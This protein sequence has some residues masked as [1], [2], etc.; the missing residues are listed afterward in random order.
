MLCEHDE[1]TLARSL[2]QSSDNAPFQG[3]TDLRQKRDGVASTITTDAIGLLKLIQSH[4]MIKESQRNASH[5]LFDAYRFF[6]N[7]R[8]RHT[9]QRRLSS[10]IQDWVRTLERLH[11]PVSHEIKRVSHF[12][13]EIL[14]ARAAKSPVAERVN[15]AKARN[16]SSL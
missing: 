16:P 13:E 14:G 2:H 10:R 12:L 6:L 1:Q 4:I 5:S 9:L 8:S 7:F 15:E 3:W 11:E